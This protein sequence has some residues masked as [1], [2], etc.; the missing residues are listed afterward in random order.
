M[1][2]Q[3]AFSRFATTLPLALDLNKPTPTCEQRIHL[4]YRGSAVDGLAVV[5]ILSVDTVATRQP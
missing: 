5:P 3:G 2:Q 4:C 1:D